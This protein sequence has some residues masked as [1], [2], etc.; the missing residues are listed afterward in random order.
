MASIFS[1]EFSERAEL[2][3]LWELEREK[4]GLELGDARS[5]RKYDRLKKKNKLKVKLHEFGVGVVVADLPSLTHTLGVIPD[6]SHAKFVFYGVS[7]VLSSSFNTH[8]NLYGTYGESL[9][10]QTVALCSGLSSMYSILN[11]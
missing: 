11:C 8:T 4:R 5:L 1:E 7:L 10:S 6:P 2:R 3:K 9:T